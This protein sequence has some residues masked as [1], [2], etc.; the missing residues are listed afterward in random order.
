MRSRAGNLLA[1]EGVQARCWRK[2]EDHD[3]HATAQTERVADFHE[4]EVESACSRGKTDL[5]KQ[6]RQNR[7]KRE[8]YGLH[9]HSQKAALCGTTLYRWCGDETSCG[10]RMWHVVVEGSGVN[11]HVV[12]L[13]VESKAVQAPGSRAVQVFPVDVVVRAVAGTLKT[14][15]VITERH[16][17]D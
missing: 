8:P 12:A 7:S 16:R 9:T 3:C 1:K 4:A 14:I 11:D 17:T 15:T 6:N 2:Q 10:I 13:E 5:R